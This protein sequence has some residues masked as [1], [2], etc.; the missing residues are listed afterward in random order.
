MKSRMIPASRHSDISRRS[1]FTLLELVVSLGISS[2]LLAGMTSSLIMAVQ[3]ND[4]EN[5][6]FFK[7]DIASDTL[8]QFNR[9]FAYAVEVTTAV[10]SNREI[11]FLVPDQNG[12]GLEELIRY[13]W[14]GVTADP[15]L[16][17]LNNGTPQVIIPEID[18]FELALQTKQITKEGDAIETPDQVWINQ[19]HSYFSSSFELRKNDGIGMDD[20]IVFSS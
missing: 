8:T 13:Q 11:E 5:G 7:V 20:N 14:S 16:R 3:A 15:L 4:L 9:E 18:Q 19:T 6:P 2:I 1:G 12:D 10:D 17:I